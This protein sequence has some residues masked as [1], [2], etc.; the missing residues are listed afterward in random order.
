[1]DMSIKKSSIVIL[2]VAMGFSTASF[3]QGASL[4]GVDTSGSADTTPAVPLTTPAVPLT[5][6]DTS[7]QG[8]L[9]GFN[10]KQAVQSAGQGVVNSIFTIPSGALQGLQQGITNKL[11]PPAAPSN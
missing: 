5:T 6:P 8:L 3:S 10:G 7:T 11:T 1:M 4:S 9:G 2:M